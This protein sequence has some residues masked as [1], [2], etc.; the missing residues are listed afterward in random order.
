MARATADWSAATIKARV[1]EKGLTLTAISVAAGLRPDACSVA[2]RRRW[3]A[4]EQAIA[5]ALDVPPETIWPSRDAIR[6]DRTCLSGRISAPAPFAQSAEPDAG[7]SNPT[8]SRPYTARSTT[9]AGTT[10]APSCSSPA[11]HRCAPS[12]RRRSRTRTS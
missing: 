2:L 1:I 8:R 4:A 5:K 9:N 3:R 12:S 10:T 6:R 11:S 7:L